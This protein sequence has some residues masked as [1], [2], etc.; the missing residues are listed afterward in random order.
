MWH[1]PFDEYFRKVMKN[2]FKSFEEIEKEFKFLEREK[3]PSFI[4][5]R[6]GRMEMGSGF[7]ISFVSDG[8]NP[9]K[10]EVKRFGPKGWEK[11]PV[12]EI[13]AKPREVIP[14]EAEKK[15]ELP[16]VKEKVIPEYNV[17]VDINEITI[18]L[19][20]EK[21][22]SEENVRVNFNPDSVEIY[23]VAPSIE[24]GY[25]STV[26]LPASVDRSRTKVEV[27][28]DKVIVKIPRRFGTK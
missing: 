15:P 3:P 7:S 26:A 21:V 4:M 24:K 1:D 8:R 6:P 25:F 19:R 5:K 16:K 14:E 10:I 13:S 2:F 22:E 12:R 20:A 17:S 23:A 27:Q 18:T 9:P 28:K 11:V